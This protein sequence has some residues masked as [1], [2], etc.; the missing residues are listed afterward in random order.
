MRALG[1]G[2]LVAVLLVVAWPI[3]AGACACGAVVAPEQTAGQRIDEG[4]IV[5]SDGP[6]EKIWMR[7][8]FGVP[9]DHAALV[10]PVPAGAA[11]SLGDDAEFDRVDTLTQPRIEHRDRYHLGFSPGHP[12]EL[13]TARAPTGAGG[14]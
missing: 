6:G 9:L 10:L 3:P 11:V 5:H 8:S 4:A 1:L 14:G 7:L 13:D 12:D 2:C